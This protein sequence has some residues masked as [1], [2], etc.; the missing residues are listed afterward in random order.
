[1]NRSAPSD[2]LNRRDFNG[3]E[4]RT[5]DHE[6]AVRPQAVDEVGHRFRA[7]GCRQN[8]LCA[9]Q[10]LQFGCRVCCS[11]VDIHLRSEFLCKRGVFGSSPDGGNLVA[12]LAGKLNSE[13]T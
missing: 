5:Y 9:T 1:M 12:K 7:R 3:I 6:L 8:D 11:A 2:E 4:S 10:F 13:V